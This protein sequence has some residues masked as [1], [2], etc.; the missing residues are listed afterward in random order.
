MPVAVHS[1]TATLQAFRRAWEV[2]A[3]FNERYFD[4]ALRM[5][6]LVAGVMPEELDAIYTKVNL[7]L[8][9]STV[10]ERLPKRASAIFSTPNML[11]LK[12]TEP[13]YDL[14]G[15]KEA[16]QAWLVDL[17]R[18]KINLRHSI[19]PC[20][21]Q[22]EIMGTGYRSPRV[23]IRNGK[24]IITSVN[25]DFF[26]VLPAPN[27][28]TVNAMDWD[29]EDCVDWVF[30]VDWTTEEAIKAR[31]ETGLYDNT[32][33]KQMLGSAPQAYSQNAIDATY[34]DQFTHI[35]G[36][37]VYDGPAAWHT[38]ISQD[39]SG[40]LPKRRRIVYW[41][42]R[43]RLVIVA[44]DKW[45]LYD[46]KP[47]LLEGIIPIIVYK[48]IRNGTNWHGISGLEMAEDVIL[49]ISLNTG[50]R[51]QH[52]VQ[53][54]FP[55]KWIRADIMG[56]HP[57]SYF[58]TVPGETLQFPDTVSDIRNA[59]FW[60]RGQEVPAQAF[61][62]DSYLRY[63][64]Q[65]LTGVKDYGKGMGGAGALANQTA[66]GITTMVAEANDRFFA[67]SDQLEHG[68]LKEEAK[69][70]LMLGAKFE[71]ETTDVRIDGA[72]DGFDWREIDPEDITDKFEVVTH[73]TAYLTD[74]RETIQRLGMMLPI[75]L[76]QPNIVDG[77]E[78][79]RQAEEVV[80]AFPR[81]ER[82]FFPDTPMMDMAAM[83][84]Q[85]AQGSVP[86]AGG[87]SSGLDLGERNARV[88]G[89]TGVEAGTGKQTVPASFAA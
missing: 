10:H 19:V 72:A 29:A 5:A 11:S 53:A 61:Q 13:L 69:L 50:L 60:D 17:L 79:L 12:A 70:L 77:R 86:Q 73:G 32:V 2:S 62:E 55:I 26:Q 56:S 21:Q 27:G 67:E 66:T 49:A 18:H 4:V 78:A 59:I 31:G 76:N 44:D 30:E 68:G 81:P 41:H 46:D 45:V 75:Y 25:R 37:V 8:A 36:G 33:V 22:V 80:A 58:N 14:P 20:L 63:I 84:G 16:S 28:G 3:S 87:A 74:K 65:E 34:R 88:Q 51:L 9:Y 7:N 1:T 47:P 85:Q 24:P 64:M 38:R 40:Q 52:L 15:M 83:M 6:K 35:V 89:K 23:T 82:L 39:D 48:A 43:D 71:T 42:M 57:K 54:L